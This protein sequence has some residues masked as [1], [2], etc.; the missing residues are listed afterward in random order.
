MVATRE[1]LCSK[2]S[3]FA[4][5]ELSELQAA[6]M[7]RVVRGSKFPKYIRQI[8]LIAIRLIRLKS[9]KHGLSNWPLSM[10]KMRLKLT[11]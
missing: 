7:F 6:K 5:N 4:R 1:E 9:V 8:T 2:Y 3:I 10:L 11:K